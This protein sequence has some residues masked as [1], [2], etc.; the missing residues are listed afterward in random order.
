VSGFAGVISLDGTPLRHGEIAA[1][2]GQVWHDDHAALSCRSASAFAP[3][4]P[5]RPAVSGTL[6]AVARLRPFR[7]PS[8]L[9]HSQPLDSASLMLAAFEQWDTACAERFDGDWSAAVWRGDRRQ[10]WLVRSAT[11][12]SGI[13]YWSNRRRF[14]FASHLRDLLAIPSA[15]TTLNLDALGLEFELAGVADEETMW[16]G[17]YRLPPGAALTLS[18]REHHQVAVWSQPH[19]IVSLHGKA[20]DLLQRFVAKYRTVVEA[21][22][23]AADGPVGLM[24]SGGFDSA[25]IAALAAP[26]LHR[27]GKRLIGFVARPLQTTPAWPQR[28][29]DEWPAACALADRL[30]GLAIEPV[31]APLDGFLQSLEHY[32]ELLGEP[33]VAVQ[34]IPW[35]LALMQ[36]A[37]MSGVRL[38]LSG[39]AGNHTISWPGR[40]PLPTAVRQ[41][42]V[43]QVLRLITSALRAGRFVRLIRASSVGRRHQA[44]HARGLGKFLEGPY[45]LSAAFADRI[46]LVPRRAATRPDGL[47]DQRV[48][49]GRR[50]GTR[51]SRWALPAASSAADAFDSDFAD[52]TADKDLAEFCLSMPNEIFWASGTRRGLLRDGF[53][54][55]LPAAIHNDRKRGLQGAD[56]ALRIMADAPRVRDLLARCRR[57]ETAAFCLDLDRAQARLAEVEGNSSAVDGPIRSHETA[58]ALAR[59]CS[60]GLFLL[61]HT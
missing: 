11:G 43:S 5:A 49:E 18:D 25:S 33:G 42:Q 28:T 48:E 23:E 9:I 32:S 20:D 44:Q 59:T 13:H 50:R 55:L 27:R 34:N 36:T 35:M 10:L 61:R 56:I 60:L 14:V 57:H 4:D 38:L 7:V 6:V 58:V 21:Q 52:P 15:E 17:V 54:D 2:R 40:D 51:I 37:Q 1:L 24:L 29:A 3:D 16:Q 45:L 19:D 26:A 47:I 46:A 22:I 41:G 8:G 39:M 30:P 53:C 12:A 31:T